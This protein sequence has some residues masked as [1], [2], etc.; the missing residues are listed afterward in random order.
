[1]IEYALSKVNDR[2]RELRSE[3]ARLTNAAASIP[4]GEAR[5]HIDAILAEI[6]ERLTALGIPPVR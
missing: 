5:S 2:A 1:M 3:H 6:N 4:A